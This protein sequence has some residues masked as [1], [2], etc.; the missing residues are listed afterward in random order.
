MCCSFVYMNDAKHAEHE[1]SGHA[2]K[3]ERVASIYL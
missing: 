2:V 1:H 3:P